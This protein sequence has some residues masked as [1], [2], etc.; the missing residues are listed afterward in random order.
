MKQQG[1]LR[2]DLIGAGIALVLA[3]AYW[4]GALRIPHS[5][6]I[7]KGVGADAL[8]RRLAIALAALAVLLVVQTLWQH[9]RA[10]APPAPAD[11]AASAQARRRH[12]RAFGMLMI[13]VVFLLIV[14]YVG[15]VP[16]IFLMICATAIY[17]G[18]PMSWRIVGLSALLTS[19]F[20]VLFDMILKIPMP[21]GVWPQ[22]WRMIGA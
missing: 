21:T 19:V 14:E 12:L 3:G 15:Y 18:R 22:L 9:R 17:N 8:P 6:L 1:S 16:A 2:K 5:S 7:G 20:Y 10:E 11:P 4:L 13:G